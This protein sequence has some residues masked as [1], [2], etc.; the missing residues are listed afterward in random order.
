M[1]MFP[2]C[3]ICWTM[4]LTLKLLQRLVYSILFLQVHVRK[5]K[6]GGGGGGG[7]VRGMC[8]YYVLLFISKC[9]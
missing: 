8:R 1:A 3:L 6:G 9:K 7:G 5:G 2:M 4:E